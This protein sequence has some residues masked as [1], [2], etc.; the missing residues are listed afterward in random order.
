MT[1][2]ELERVAEPFFTTRAAQGGTGLGVSI[3]RSIVREHNGSLVYV[4]EPDRGTTVSV[5]LP[6]SE[7]PTKGVN[8][9]GTTP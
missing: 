4:S 9:G 5:R 7:S 6:I 2:E 3:S 8:N 1:R